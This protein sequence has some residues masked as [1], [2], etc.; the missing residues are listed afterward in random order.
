M[1]LNRFAL[2]TMQAALASATLGGLP[3]TAIAAGEV[4]DQGGRIVVL[5]RIDRQS[6]ILPE[7]ISV[8]RR[9]V[10][11]AVDTS[12]DDI[13]VS[14]M[15]GVSARVGDVMPI[16]LP[17][18]T[19]DV[20]IRGGRIATT[21]V[22]VTGLG[23]IAPRAGRAV[24]SGIATALGGGSAITSRTPSVSVPGVSVNAPA[25]G[26]SVPSVSVDTPAV[27]VSV[28]GVSVNVPAV[29]VS[30]PGVSVNVPA[31][32]VSVPAVS[33]QAPVP[34]AGTVSGIMVATDELLAAE[35]L[36][37]STTLGN[38]ASTVQ[39][40]TNGPGAAM[41]VPAV[42]SAVALDGGAAIAA[43]LGGGAGGRI[44]STVADGVRPI[45]ATTSGIGAQIGSN[46][47]AIGARLGAQ[48]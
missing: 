23:A 8:P 6:A 32:G 21:T 30:V 20:G 16:Q 7:P 29:G 39:F 2:R 19:G 4:G 15:D 35:R 1:Q 22:P 14:T 41:P 27:G 12:P 9:T 42:T 34:T 31:V 11:V 33:V 25:V 36:A 47:G 26:V 3:Q 45:S 44:A 43:T 10:V 18:V 37:P 5:T 13:V 24:V 48:R 28:P 17:T 40:S 46:L 38:V